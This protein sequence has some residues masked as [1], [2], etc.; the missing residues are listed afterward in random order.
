V[1]ASVLAA[2]VLTTVSLGAALAAESPA[3]ASLS[4]TWLATGSA[5]GLIQAADPNVAMSTFDQPGAFVTRPVPAGWTSTV[6][7]IF[8]SFAS[9]QHKIASNSLDPSIRAAVYDNEA[10]PFTPTNEQ[11]HPGYYS[12]LFADLA[13]QHGLAAIVAPATDLTTVLGCP[14]STAYQRYLNCRL[15]AKTARYADGIDIQAQHSEA[16]ATV[17]A[18]FVAAAATQA[19]SANSAVTVLAGL[20]TGPGGQTVTSSQLYR[21][22]NA[23][24]STVAGWWLNV[25]SQSAACP[26]CGAADAQVAVDFLHMMAQSG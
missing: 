21:A 12:Q 24:L 14:G 22:A 18:S 8:P 9:L 1:A 15:A 2:L 5:V 11:L 3:R 25:P 13:H 6:T 19:R 10:W 26:N 17:Y 4:H 23:T 20:S 7:A 16:N